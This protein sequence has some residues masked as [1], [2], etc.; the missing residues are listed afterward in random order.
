[1]GDDRDQNMIMN[2]E[3]LSSENWYLVVTITN[4]NTP[5]QFSFWTLLIVDKHF[6]IKFMNLLIMVSVRQMTDS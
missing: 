3:S 6:K 5:F 4:K 2:E 1:M